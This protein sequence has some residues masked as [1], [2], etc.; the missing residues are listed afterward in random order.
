LR[1]ARRRSEHPPVGPL[2]E[3]ER[4]TIDEI[5]RAI[6]ESERGGD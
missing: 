2:E 5:D 1:D 6:E 3:R 4:H